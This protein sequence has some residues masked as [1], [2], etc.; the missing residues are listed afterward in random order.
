MLLRRSLAGLIVSLM[1]ACMAVALWRVLAPGG[2]TGAKVAMLLSGLGAAPWVGFCVAN[3]LIGFVLSLTRP[4]VPVE[5]AVTGTLPHT[6]IAVTVRNEDMD[7]VLPPL[8]RL[9]DGL[10]TAGAGDAFAVFVLSDTS[11]AAEAEEHAVARFRSQDRMPERVRYRR[12]RGNAGFKAG[13]IMDFLDHHAEGFTLMLVLDAD[14]AMTPQ[15]VLR[16]VTAMRDDPELGIMQH[17]TVGLPASSAFPRLFQFGMRAGMRT[18][19]AALDWWQGDECVYWGHNAIVRIAPFRDHCRLPKLPNGG[20]ILSHD[21]VEAAMLR[22][23]G[24]KIRLLP[25]EDGSYEA[26]PPALPEFMR[27]ELRWLAGNFEYRHLLRMPGLRPMG[28]WQLI[29]AILLFGCTPFYLIFLAAAAWAAATD[30]VSPF[31]A[32]PALILTLL[33][34]GGLYAPKLL[35]YLEVLVSADKR[36]RYGGAGRM[37]AGMALETLF[38]LLMDAINTWAKTLAMARIAFG[39][40]ASWTPQ[41]RDDR[42]VSWSEAAWLLWPQTMVGIV[43][44]ACFAHAGWNAV[45]WAAPFAGGLVAAIPFCVI[46]SNPRAGAWLLRKR[47]AAIPEEWHPGGP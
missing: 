37:L 25:E 36:A 16:L 5:I 3:G 28:R 2:W 42:G 27:R 33:W 11:G 8:R 44:F 19:A 22:G 13:N 4:A 39:L 7:Q 47:L 23:A 31:P 34:A 10:D 1:S 41:N 45:L 29:Q 32:G 17:L 35:G 6:A 12:R 21:Q 20:D 26:N 14:S 40:R 43:V 24:W 15:A 9:L 18:W 46:T 30:T 38:I